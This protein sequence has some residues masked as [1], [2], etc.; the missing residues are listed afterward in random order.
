MVNKNMWDWL[1]KA[2][3]RKDSSF[4]NLEKEKKRQGYNKEKEINNLSKKAMAVASPEQ[5]KA[6]KDMQSGD[7]RLFLNY[8]KEPIS[9][10]SIDKVLELMVNSV[11]GDTSQLNKELE[12]YARKKGWL[13]GFE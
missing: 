7:E 11:E 9:Q 5:K 1:D 2:E 4:K 12:K 13:K 8:L 3:G 10:Y 6:F